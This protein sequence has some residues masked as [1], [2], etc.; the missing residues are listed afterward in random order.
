M[1]FADVGIDIPPGRN[2]QVYTTCPQCREDRKKKYAKCLS[3]QIDQGIWNCHH[4]GESGSLRTGWK[5]DG[6]SPRPPTPSVKVGYAKPIWPVDGEPS[7]DVYRWFEQRSISKM[8]VDQFKVSSAIAPMPHT[9]KAEQVI[10]FP[11][12]KDGQH[13]N[14]KYRMLHD[15]AFKME[16]NCERT[17]YNL[18]SLHFEWSPFE[19]K[20]IC[21]SVV[22]CEGEVDVMSFAQAGY[23]SVVSV[24]NGAPPAHATDL[25]QHL[26][27][28]EGCYEKFET[29]NKIIIACDDDPPGRRLRE[30]LARRFGPEKCW[31][32]QYPEGCKD[33]NEVL[34]HYGE[35]GIQALVDCAKEWPIYGVRSTDDIKDE[36]YDLYDHGMPGGLSTGWGTVDLHYLIQPGEVTIVTGTPFSGKSYWVEALAI[37]LCKLHDWRVASYSPESNPLKR[38]VARLIEKYMQRSFRAWN[39][40]QSPVMSRAEVEQGRLWVQ[41][42]FRFFGQDEQAET[43]EALLDQMKAMV[44]RYGTKGIILDP[45]NNI[46]HLRP[47]Q[48]TETEYVSESLSQ[49]RRFARNYVTHMWIVAHPAKMT[50]NKKG[51]YEVPHPYD[52][53][54]SAHWFN[55]ADNCLTV[56]RDFKNDPDRLRLYIWKVKNREN[57]PHGIK[58]D[59]GIPLL[60]QHGWGGYEEDVPP[61]EELAF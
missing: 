32:V 35:V 17:F 41:E 43:L 21:P 57:S 22:I 9:Q 51:Q 31:F 38:Y 55:K 10:L 26:S 49:I 52:I 20:K 46:E 18:D 3:V 59:E 34:V 33:A 44:R 23:Q 50:R 15:K 45:W 54:G 47:P 2:G 36:L 16:T 6:Q 27:Y 7:E 11:Y 30:E 29:V 14:T 24:P 37:N 13:I 25:T 42:H 53:S 60:W 12:F 56:W 4:C 19:H 48:Q 61:E 28:L 39:G 40:S 58:T 1:D 8:I 5:R